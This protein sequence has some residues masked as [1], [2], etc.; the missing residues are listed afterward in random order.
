MELKNTLILDG[1]ES[2]SKVMSHL[3][4]MP[5]VIITKNGK[6]Y[7][8]IDHRSVTDGFKK[9]YNIKCE[10][11]VVKPP[12][13]VKTAN[14][15]ERVAYFLDGHFKAL[16]VVDEDHKP[17][18]I[19][20]RVELLKDMVHEG[21]MPKG[22]VEDLMSAPV[23]TIEENKKISDI[24]SELKKRNVRRLVVTRGK[25]PVGLVSTFDI[26][27]WKDRHNL[28][29]GRK[30][31]HLSEPIDYDSM[32]L[33]GFVR[34]DITTIDRTTTIEDAA[35]KMIKKE[36]SALV[37][38]SDN[39]AVGVLS[40]LDI[41]KY[42]KDVLEENV[43]VRVSGLDEEN[44]KYYKKI[45][46]KIGQILDKFSGSFNIR[47][48]KIHVKEGKKAFNV[49]IY[50][51]TDEGHVSLQGERATIKETVDELA[52]ELSKVLKKKKEM[53]KAK[54]RTISYSG[55]KKYGRGKK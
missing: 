14:I 53:R 52:V 17:I 20:T 9:S 38:M 8:V 30:D 27:A 25:Y 54:P 16:P 48:A 28:A 45:Q 23:Y 1:S 47:N 13:I 7:G 5:A 12:V 41:F 40:A 33:S 37:V 6:Y 2:L 49:S 36:V 43:E 19:T 26:S 55:T 29:G 10:N 18:A 22:N 42:I 32:Y 31:V 39:K 34:P 51:D 15:A 24:K 50:L 4:E 3:S 21:I 35:K 11:A 44:M 46:E